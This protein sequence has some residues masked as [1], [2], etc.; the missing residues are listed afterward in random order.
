[1]GSQHLGKLRKIISSD[2]RLCERIEFPL[3]MFY[4]FQPEPGAELDWKGP[5]LLD[6]IGGEGVGFND[7]VLIAKGAEIL[8][9]MYLP[10]DS[11]PVVF[12]GKVS[13]SKLSPVELKSAKKIYSYGIHIEKY[14]PVT[15][16]RFLGFMSDQILGKYMD[17]SGNLKDI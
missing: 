13:W 12:V 8:I 4:A 9:R 1:M 7:S 2:K 10:E 15:E 11:V 6:N 3:K 14:D 5:V 16:S 17:D